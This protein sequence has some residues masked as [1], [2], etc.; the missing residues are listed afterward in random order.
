MFA[1]TL[2]PTADTVSA[3]VARIA[4]GGVYGKL[5]GDHLVARPLDD[6]G[7]RRS[8]RELIAEDDGVAAG[9]VQRRDFASHPAWSPSLPGQSPGDPAEARPLTCP[10]ASRLAA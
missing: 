2:P 8:Q 7:I 3:A 6:P 4:L 9:L 1:W 5:L 10:P